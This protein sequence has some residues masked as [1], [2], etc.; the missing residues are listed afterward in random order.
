M[1]RFVGFL[2]GFLAPLI[3]MAEE[4]IPAECDVVELT[5]TMIPKKNIDEQLRE[6][7]PLITLISDTLGVPVEMVRAS[8]YES[9]IDSIVSGGVDVAVLGPAAYMIARRRNSGIEPFASLAVEGGHFTPE[10]SFY[11]SILVVDSDSA[12]SEPEDLKGAR[13]ALGDPSSTSG[14]VVPKAIF[15]DVVGIPFNRFFGAL[16]YAGGHDKAMNALIDRQ[17]DAAFVSSARADEYLKRGMIGTDSFRVLWRSPPLHY[18]PFVFRN[19]LCHSVRQKL[20]ELMTTPSPRLRDFL[21]SQ[22][23]TRITPV[24]HED[25]QA[26]E[27]LM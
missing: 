11:N 27:S 3:V 20:L 5:F 15:P 12:V 23:A 21:D 19:D 2:V 26:L 14:A 17:V 6:Y 24:R 10:G 16:V 7:G 9:V 25:Y 8:S 13:V 1:F 4:T 22:H 18:D